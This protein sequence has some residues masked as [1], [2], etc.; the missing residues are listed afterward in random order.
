MRI[1]WTTS[2]TED[3][4]RLPCVQRFAVEAAAAMT[5]QAHAVDRGALR[6]GDLAVVWD[7]HVAMIVGNGR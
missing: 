3:F 1:S 5:P 6:P 7:G 2:P 4:A